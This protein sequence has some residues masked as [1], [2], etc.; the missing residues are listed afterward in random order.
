MSTPICHRA[1]QGGAG[2]LSPHPRDIAPD[3]PGKENSPSPS[4]QTPQ[5]Q[6]HSKFYELVSSLPMKIIN[7]PED[8]SQSCSNTELGRSGVLP[9]PVQE[10]DQCN[11][12]HKLSLSGVQT[13]FP[14]RLPGS[15]LPPA[16]LWALYSHGSW[17]QLPES[18]LARCSRGQ[19]PSR[20][21]TRALPTGVSQ[22]SPA[23]GAAHPL[24]RVSFPPLQGTS[25]AFL[26]APPG[27]A[28]APGAAVL[29]DPHSRSP[30]LPGPNPA[31]GLT[32]TPPGRGDTA[33]SARPRGRDSAGRQHGQAAS[34]PRAPPVP[35]GPWP[36]PRRAGSPGDLRAAGGADRSRSCGRGSRRGCVGTPPRCRHAAG[37]PVAPDRTYR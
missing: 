34:S 20:R 31:A 15:H 10:R 8:P 23:S 2:L 9:P 37:C 27:S 22:S 14:P 29:L 1:L 4:R 33:R 17:R 24:T 36:A 21:R 19:A 16:S 12:G 6:P 7:R 26:C 30:A 3:A 25:P 28:G 32:R 18:T 5:T 11:A 13:Y 35:A